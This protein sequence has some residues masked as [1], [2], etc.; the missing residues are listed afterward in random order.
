MGFCKPDLADRLNFFPKKLTKNVAKEKP[1]KGKKLKHLVSFRC[2]LIFRLVYFETFSDFFFL[3]C[4]SGGSPGF[5][6]LYFHRCRFLSQSIHFLGKC[7]RCNAEGEDRSRVLRDSKKESPSNQ[8]RR[9]ERKNSLP[10]SAAQRRRPKHQ[11]FFSQSVTPPLP[12][13]LQ[14]KYQQL[15]YLLI[16]LSFFC[17]VHPSAPPRPQTHSSAHS[18]C[19]QGDRMS[20]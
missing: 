5:R 15:T 12:A 13:L 11:F 17:S 10:S 7:S 19:P 18:D 9:K 3:L 1:E 4:A 2:R 20:S 8:N 6:S 14:K 16:S